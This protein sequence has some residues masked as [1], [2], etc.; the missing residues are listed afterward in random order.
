LNDCEVF[1]V[2]PEGLPV[3]YEVFAGNRHDVTTLQDIVRQMEDKYGQAQRVW[4]VDRG[5]ASETN[6]AWLRA[7]GATY[8]VGT[9]RS[10]LKAH[11]AALLDQSGWQEARPGLEVKLL[12]TLQERERFILCRSPDRAAKERAMLDRQLERLKGQLNKIHTG[13]ARAPEGNLE[14]AGRRIGHWLGKYPAAAGVL[15]VTLNKDACGRA[16]GLA[17]I[18]RISVQFSQPPSSRG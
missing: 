12:A 17:L 14:K 4:V 15:G 13:L 11:Q 16:C 1:F 5:I 3:A 18:E 7:R 8:L 10:Q 6:L 9:P 2:T